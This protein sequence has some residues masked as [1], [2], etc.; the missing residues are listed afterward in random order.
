MSCLFGAQLRIEWFNLDLPVPVF[1]TIA[2]RSS[3][4]KDKSSG[5]QFEGPALR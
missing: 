2:N 5:H 3:G 1:L 4:Q